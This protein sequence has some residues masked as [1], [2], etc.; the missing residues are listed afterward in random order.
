MSGIELFLW[1]AL[2]GPVELAPGVMVTDLRKFD[3]PITM[4]P[5]ARKEYACVH[6]WVS[7]DQGKSWKFHQEV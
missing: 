5:E 1:L 2:F 4:P 3:L 6:L 7:R